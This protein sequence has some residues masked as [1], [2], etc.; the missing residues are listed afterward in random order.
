FHLPAVAPKDCFLSPA[1]MVVDLGR[2][3]SENISGKILTWLQRYRDQPLEEDLWVKS[4]IMPPWLLSL[5]RFAE[6]DPAWG[7]VDL[8][9]E[10]LTPQETKSLLKMGLAREDMLRLEMGISSS[11]RL[12]PAL[13]ICTAGSKLLHFSGSFK[14]WLPTGRSSPI[15]ALPQVQGPYL[16]WTQSGESELTLHCKLDGQELR[17]LNCSSLWR[18]FLT[19]EQECG[20]KGYDAGWPDVDK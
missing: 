14:P 4:L 8:G 2:W 6:L 19:A 11:G 7:C 9:S 15:C 13:H 20:L 17:V 1:L 16:G 18:A 12:Q 3:Q 10:E 5:E